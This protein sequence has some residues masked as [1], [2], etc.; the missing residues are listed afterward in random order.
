[1][2]EENDMRI[3]ILTFHRAHNYGAVLQC[4]ALQEILRRMGHD[5]Q[6]IDYRQPWIE[7]F[8]NLFCRNMIRRNASSASR[9]FSYLKSSM[10]KWILAPSKAADF[11]DFRERFLNLSLPCQEAIPQL[12]DC[13]VIGSDQLWSLHC[14]GGVQDKVYMGDFERPAGSRLVGYAVS[15]DMK[16]IQSSAS[17][18][19]AMVPGFDALSMREKEVAEAVAALTGCPCEVCLDPTLLTDASLWNPLMTPVEKEEY[20]LMYEVRWRK[21]SKGLL[22]RKAD[23]LAASIGGGC[24]VIDL[25]TMKYSVRDFVSLFRYARYVVTTSFHG[26]VFSILFERPFYALPLWNGYDLRYVELLHSLGLDARLIDPDV[27]MDQKDI[28]YGQVKNKLEILKRHSIDYID[29][30]LNL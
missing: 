25:S 26:I 27:V 8:Y 4:Y 24:T 28:D 17:L 12:Y 15:A 7:D 13:Y 21:E 30:A 10:K 19:K 6:V 9:L 20:V 14:L 16:S 11:R 1:M 5:V 29:K 23:E 22:R 2:R 18:L 3:G